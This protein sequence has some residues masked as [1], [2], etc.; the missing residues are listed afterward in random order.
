MRPFRS[1]LYMPGSNARALEKARSLAADALILDLEDACAPNK[2]AEARQLIADAVNTGGYGQRYLLVRVNGLDTEWCDDDLEVISAC[3]PHAIL[4]PK[5]DRPDDIHVLAEKMETHAGYSDTKIWAMIETPLGILNAQEI[6]GASN[7]L[8]GFVLGTNDLIKD[9]HALHVPDRT[10][11]LFALSTSVL[12]ARAHGLVCLDGVY[13]DIRNVDGLAEECR[14]GRVLGFDG[15]TL[16]HPAQIEPA[17]AAFSPTDDDIAEAR[18][19]VSAYEEALSEGRAV[20]VVNG[21][22]VEN[23]HVENARRLI[24]QNEAILAMAN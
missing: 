1:M 21:R 12:A 9:M 13:N 8:E 5:V 14:Q 19:Y 24:A 20:A 2:K 17:N 15:K 18:S 23:L 7:H 3:A 22:I 10:A 4:L 16:I 11:V 6:A